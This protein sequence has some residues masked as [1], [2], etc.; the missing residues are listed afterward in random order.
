MTSVF[1]RLR[2]YW[3]GMGVRLREGVRPD[4]IRRFERTYGVSMP[5]EVR[6]YFLTVDGRD[7]DDSDEHV[8]TFLPLDLV[9]PTSDVL[10][11]CRGIP[12]HV[13]ALKS[14]ESPD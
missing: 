2:L 14:I 12:P 6:E 8:T 7:P 11:E 3:D 5:A 13:D 10:P 1:Q 4:D 9:R